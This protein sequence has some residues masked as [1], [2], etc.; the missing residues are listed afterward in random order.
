MGV[1]SLSTRLIIQNSNLWRILIFKEECGWG[2]SSIGF[3]SYTCY[4]AYMRNSIHNIMMLHIRKYSG[5]K[6]KLTAEEGKIKVFCSFRA[7]NFLF[8]SLVL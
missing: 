1:D 2:N 3:V 6:R 5:Q 7:S 4:N 8:F